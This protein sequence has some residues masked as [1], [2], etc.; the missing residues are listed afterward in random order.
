[1]TL[2]LGFGFCPLHCICSRL[3]DVRLVEKIAEERRSE[4][5]VKVRRIRI[6]VLGNAASESARDS[7]ATETTKLR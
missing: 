1:M 3:V 4:G 6:R 7:D 2:T 5:S